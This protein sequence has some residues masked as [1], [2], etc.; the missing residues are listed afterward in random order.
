MDIWGTRPEGNTERS[1]K[2]WTIKE[3]AFAVHGDGLRL[4]SPERNVTNWRKGQAG[5]PNNR[6]TIQNIESAL[7][8]DNPDFATW[9][10]DMRLARHRPREDHAVRPNRL[11]ALHGEAASDQR[12]RADPT[13]SGFKNFDRTE[14]YQVLWTL[15]AEFSKAVTYA[16]KPD[17]ALPRLDQLNVSERANIL[18]GIPESDR[19][20]ITGPHE[21]G[22]LE[23]LWRRNSLDE[24]REKFANLEIYVTRRRILWSNAIVI[25]LD[26]LG[27]F[28]GRFLAMFSGGLVA[29]D[30]FGCCLDEIEAII[31]QLEGLIREALSQS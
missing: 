23:Y 18:L 15:I 11:T 31:R 29:N 2:P 27:E 4:G 13:S 19:H 14:S 26:R 21:Q 17:F 24:S 22:M 6:T 10:Q 16:G 7:F 20:W 30:K 8:G 3:F 28:Y 5:P 1:G 12:V 9:K 25:D